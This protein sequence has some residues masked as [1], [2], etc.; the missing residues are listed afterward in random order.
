MAAGY[1]AFDVVGACP[2]GRAAPPKAAPTGC[3]FDR[4]EGYVSVA[5][6]VAGEAVVCCSG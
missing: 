4:R 1:L 3:G 6:E 5:G 2:G